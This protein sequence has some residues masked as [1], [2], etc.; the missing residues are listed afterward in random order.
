MFQTYVTN[1]LHCGAC[2]V[3]YAALPVL[4]KQQWANVSHML[5]FDSNNIQIEMW[6]KL[7]ATKTLT[8]SKINN[9]KSNEF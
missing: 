9:V 8:K 1:M 5:G 7:R 3:S 6:Y 2:D 4:L